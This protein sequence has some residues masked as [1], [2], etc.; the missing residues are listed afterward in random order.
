MGF[1]ARMLG[2]GG[3]AVNEAERQAREDGALI[4]DV[5]ERDEY[6]AGHVK[7]SMRI[8]LAQVSSSVAKLPADRTILVICRSGNRSG[9]A[10]AVLRKAGL[11]AVN[12]SGGM[13]SWKRAGLPIEPR[14]GRVL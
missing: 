13:L 5:R 6:R 8:G 4:L 12:V 11:D 14:S 1:L 9:H 7:G 3:V 2:G 10:T